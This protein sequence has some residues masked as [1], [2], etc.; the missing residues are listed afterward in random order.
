MARTRSASA[1]QKVL[2]AALE[3]VAEHGIDGTSMDAV[4]RESGVSKATIYKH[5]SD[6]EA[7][8]LEMLAEASGLHSRPKFDSGDTRGDMIALLS[9][10]PPENAAVRERVLP[11]IVAYSAR[12]RTFGIT[13]RK[14]VMDPAMRELRH[15]IE[16]GIQ[17]REL[18]PNLNVELALGLLLGP[19]LYWQIFQKDQDPPVDFT[20]Q[21]AGVVDVFWKAFGTAR[22]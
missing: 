13:W 8:L 15:L 11:H 9:Y 17:K 22:R 1:H 16:R 4:A 5:W 2:K 18:K 19:M 20:P 21:A 14:M 7:M 6:K 10:R 3:L 12:N